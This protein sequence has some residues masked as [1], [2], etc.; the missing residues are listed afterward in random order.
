MA[1]KVALRG[2]QSEAAVSRRPAQLAGN[3]ECPVQATNN[4]TRT[5][6]VLGLAASLLNADSSRP[7]QTTTTVGVAHSWRHSYRHSTATPRRLRNSSKPLQRNPVHTHTRALPTLLTSR[8]IRPDS[9]AAP[10][11]N[12][13]HSINVNVNSSRRQ[14]SHPIASPQLACRAWLCERAS[15]LP[16]TTHTPHPA[17]NVGHPSLPSLEHGTRTQPPQPWHSAASRRVSK[18]TSPFHSPKLCAWV[19]QVA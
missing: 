10:H 6:V 15:N 11:C 14:I 17:H 13:V 18:I 8:A 19:F 2:L 16:V 5:A 4:T 12:C 9:G 7:S 1:T 3:E